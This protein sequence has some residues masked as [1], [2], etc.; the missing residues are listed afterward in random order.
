MSKQFSDYLPRGR[1][2]KRWERL[3]KFAGLIKEINKTIDMKVT[4]RGWCYLLEGK[5]FITKGE[6][7]KVQ[8]AINECRKMGFLPID[9][10]AQDESRGFDGVETPTVQDPIAYFKD[11]M[12]SAYYAERYYTS[13]WWDGEECYL[14]MLVEKI[15]L[16]SLFK[17]ICEEYH[18]PIAT[19]RGWSDILQRAEMARRFKE[20]E[21]RGLKSVLL[22]CGDF[23]PYGN[24]I[25]DFIRKNLVDI[26][27]GT[28]YDP[29]NLEIDRFGLNFE[30]I[31]ENDLTW[32]D[33][34]ESG[35]GKNMALMDNR[36]VREYIEQYGE[37]KCEA[38]ALIVV[39]DSARDLC[40]EAIESHIGEGALERFEEKEE[41]VKGQLD[42]YRKKIGADKMLKK[43]TGDN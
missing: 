2:E 30:F 21:E 9:F 27:G 17:P 1:G 26:Y 18:I 31:E 32:I 22:Y 5:N 28:R 8:H 4:S 11:L 14:Q 36:I 19:G 24:A 38:N 42:E 7:E 12:N 20:A 39:P 6:F 10:V 35:S 3:A 43:M 15:D 37:R 29:T 23:D 13:D 25:S 41:E 16:K 40:R 33:N 34:L